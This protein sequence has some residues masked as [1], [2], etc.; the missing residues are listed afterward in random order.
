[1][2]KSTKTILIILAAMM[3]VSAA[4]IC[5]TIIHTSKLGLPLGDMFSEM[6]IYGALGGLLLI[7]LGF[8]YS[9]KYPIAKKVLIIVGVYDLVVT[10]IVFFI[11]GV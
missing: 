1:M 3:I 9:K 6:Y 10:A 5:V 7:G 2:K 4:M 11:A 8:L